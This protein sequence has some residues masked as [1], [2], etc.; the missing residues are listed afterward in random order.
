MARALILHNPEARN[1]P[2]PSFMEQIARELSWAGFQS[3]V[4]ASRHRGELVILARTAARDGYDRVVVCG[5]DGSVREAAEGLRK[6]GVPLAIVPLGTIN[7]LAWEMGLP[8]GRPAACVEAA[9]RGRPRAVGLGNIDGAAFT[10]CASAGVDA[11]AVAGVDLLMKKQTGGWAYVHAGIRTL[12]E[13]RPPLFQ[14]TLPNGRV[15]HACQVFAARARLYGGRLVLA[16]SARLQ[17]PTL[18]LLAVA[19]PFFP[20]VPI[21]MARLMG[22]GI[23]GAP[24]VTS[25]AV[26]GFSLESDGP[27][28]CQADGDS[29]GQ[30]PTSFRSEQE[31]L[32]LVFPC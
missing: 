11:L 28:P 3:E 14:V 18:R 2:E 1:A 24:G 21:A 29:M 26:E 20:N 7:V 8:A 15:L 5:G 12:L 31:A 30:T 6:T 27:C 9:A 32:T 16:D 22:P 10:F 13:R 25:L 23:E 17:A 4:A 19:P